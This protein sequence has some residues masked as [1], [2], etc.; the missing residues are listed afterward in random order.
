MGSALRAGGSIAFVSALVLSGACGPR[1]SSTA[2]SY[3]PAPCPNPIVAGEPQY[4][5]GQGFDCGYLTV[6]E[7][8]NLPNSRSIRIPVARLRAETTNPKHDPIVF[9]AGGPGRRAA[10]VG[11]GPS[12]LGADASLLPRRLR[13]RRG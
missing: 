2:A 4:D 7:N 8:R 1:R 9:L 10:V 12:R 13:P 5:L 11:R 6:P 3:H